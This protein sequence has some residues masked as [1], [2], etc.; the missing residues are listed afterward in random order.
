[1]PCLTQ[2][3]LRLRSLFN[4]DPDPAI[5]ET[6]LKRDAA[7]KPLIACN[8]GLRIPG[9]LDAFELSLRAVLGQQVSVKAATTLFGRFVSVFGKPVQTPFPDLDRTGPIAET[10]ADAS[11]QTLIDLGLTRR[12]ALTVHRL[13][14]L[15]AD[16]TLR[17]ESANRNQVI[18]QL[19]AL[20]GIGPWTAQYIAMRALGDADAFPASDLGLL[21]ALQMNKPAEM[22]RRTATWQPWRAY[23]AIHLWHQLSTEADTALKTHQQSTGSRGIRAET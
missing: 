16:G 7:L 12:R 14:Q 18:E 20:P 11:L 2:L 13:A 19:R 5:I 23:G 4:L 17:L 9:T 6:H 22:L 3:Q 15:T 1:M 21:R 8:P 10:I